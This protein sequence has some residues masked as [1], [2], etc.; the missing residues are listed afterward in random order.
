M[1]SQPEGLTNNTALKFKYVIEETELKKFELEPNIFLRILQTG[2]N[3]V[4]DIRK[5]YKGYPTKKGIR[6]GMSVFREI[7]KL[8]ID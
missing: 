4:I 5:Y 3:K 2:N 7:Q 1:E 6:F 8:C